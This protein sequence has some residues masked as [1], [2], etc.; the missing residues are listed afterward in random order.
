MNGYTI[1][2]VLQ[3]RKLKAYGISN[4]AKLTKMVG[5]GGDF[6]IQVGLT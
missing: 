3:I 1:I 5:H 6:Q 4:L 2:L